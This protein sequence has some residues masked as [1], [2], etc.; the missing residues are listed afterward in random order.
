[1][2]RLIAPIFAPIFAMGTAASAQVPHDTARCD[3]ALS[4]PSPDSQTTRVSLLI[5]PFDKSD[6]LSASHESLIATAIRQFLVVP[7]PLVLNTY[8]T[9]TAAPPIE[10]TGA[11]AVLTLRSVYRATLHRDGLFSRIRTV[12]GTRNAG[13]DAAFI[14]ALQQ[15]SESRAL[16]EPAPS[17]ATFSGD[18]MDV[19]FVVAPDAITLK[20]GGP[21]PPAAGVT[22]LIQM[23]LPVRRITRLVEPRRGNP[24]PPYPRRMRDA[25]VTGE[26]LLEFVVDAAGQ[27]DV[28]SVQVQSAT[29]AEF[30][31]S[32]FETLPRLRFDPLLVEGCPVRSLARMPFQFNLIDHPR[33]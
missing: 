21:W 18:S 1:M 16:P 19:R 12:G 27:V 5:V 17:A 32:V 11:R 6:K 10:G 33:R 7:R 4:A 28:T 31:E 9:S 22:P 3:A 2:R 23:R 15:L 13:F 26:T 14:E 20:H 25:N 24:A 29:A 30:V 8:E